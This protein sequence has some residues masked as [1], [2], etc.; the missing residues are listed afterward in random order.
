VVALQDSDG[1]QVRE[2]YM[3]FCCKLYWRDEQLIESML[4]AISPFVVVDD[5][6]PLYC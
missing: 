6:D 2:L 3:E 4:L 5:D 1:A